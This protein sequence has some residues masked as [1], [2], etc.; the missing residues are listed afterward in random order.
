[1]VGLAGLP[2]L[3]EKLY[4][5]HPSSLRLFEEIELDR[6]SDA[7]RRQVINMG[8]QKANE[9]STEQTSITDSALES[10]VI[11]SEG[12]PHFIQQFSAS[13]FAVD[14]DG[15]LDDDD[16]GQGAFARGGG[17]DQIAKTYYRHD[18]YKKIQADSYREVLR[19][20]SE[21]LDDWWTKKEIRDRFNAGDTALKNAL[22]A[23][24]ERH[25]IVAREGVRGVYRLQNRGFAA[26][27]RIEA[28]RSAGQFPL[29]SS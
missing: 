29:P 11:L 5:S 14:K 24:T 17:L 10:L 26:W 20:M 4:E 21:R 25:I 22:Y 6:L 19:I 16:V 15:I 8:L 7:E 9:E 13:A 1:M 23:L 28:A 27:V 12:F 2:N 18:Y 3:R